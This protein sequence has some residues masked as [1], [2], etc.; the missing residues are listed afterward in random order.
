MNRFVSSATGYL[1]ARLFKPLVFRCDQEFVHEQMVGV[2]QT[3]GW[4][5]A[6][7]GLISAAWSYQNPLLTKTID[8]IT[9][10]NP[11]GLSAGFDYNGQLT[12]ILP[13]VGFGFHSIGT[14]TLEPYGGNPKPRLGRL[15]QSRAL[16]VNKGLKNDGAVA[17]IARLEKQHFTIPTGISIASTNKH[18]AS[19]AAQIEDIIGCFQLFQQSRVQNA[20]FELNISCPNTFGGE[21]FTASQ[22]LDR[23]LDKMDTLHLQKPLY[24]KMPIDQ[25]EN[26]TEDLLE[27]IHKHNV[28]GVI[29]GNLTKDKKNPAVTAEDRQKW[30]HTPGNLSG[31]PTW[32]RSNTLIALAR[33]KLGPYATIIGTGGVFNA[34]DAYTKFQLGANLVQLI[35]GMIYEGP[36]MVGQINRVLA[37]A[38]P[39]LCK[40]L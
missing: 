32:Q 19:E 18:F 5:G 10:P 13:A 35:T 40:E 28:Q 26:E 38:E 12:Q 15:P 39:Q 37:Q 31:K 17:I 36:Q 34:C 22:K 27:L 7:R 3:L 14:V 21:P 25:S 11:I 4:S 9:F 2:G 29:I 6:A 8:D 20:Y 30:E 33:R 1:Y 24:L 23:L 16:I